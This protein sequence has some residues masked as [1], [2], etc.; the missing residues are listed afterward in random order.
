VFLSTTLDFPII[1][2]GQ[3]ASGQYNPAE[4][5]LDGVRALV[6]GTE[7]S[8]VSVIQC[9]RNRLTILALSVALGLAVK[10]VEHG[11]YNNTL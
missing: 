11:L 4:S 7:V 2:D 9:L 10:R 8:V 5:R 6:L 1:L 3:F